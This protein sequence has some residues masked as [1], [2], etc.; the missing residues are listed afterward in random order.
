VLELLERSSQL[1]ELGG[2][3]AAAE[4]GGR[5]VLVAGEAGIGK[6][7]FVKRFSERHSGDVRIL[8]GACDPLLTPRAL[9]P[10]HDIGR[11][12]GGRLAAL[13]TAGVPREQ[14]F[15]A[16]LDE[17]E[18]C[19]SQQVIVVEDAHWADEATLD[20]LVFLGR[21]IERIRALLIVTYRDDELVV[22]HPLRMVIGRLPPE[23]VRHLRLAPLSAAA[24]ADL[25]RRAGRAANGL[26]ALT[27]GNPLLVTEVLAVRDTGVPLT[28]RDL[29]LA[30]LAGLPPD[31]QEV[32]HLVAV[33]PTRTELWL[34]DEALRPASA[35]V[36]A[37]V[38]A[39]LLMA[40]S[41]AVWFR[42]E[43]LR[44]A[45]EGSLSALARRE[46]NQRVLAALAGGHE[47]RVDV[48][49][50]VHHARE[51]GHIDA[52]LQYAPEAAKQAAAVAAHREAVGHYRAV[53]P[54]AGR[55]SA[56]VRAEVLEGYSVEA[57]MSGLTTEAV[58]ARRA[59][60]ALREAAGDREKLGETLRW[61]SRLHWWDGNRPE[62]EA[63]VARAIAVL[64]T[65]PPG[66]QLAMAYS[67]RAGLDML[68][69]RDEAA[70]RGATRTI[71]LAGQ[72]DDREALAHALAIIGSARLNVGDLGGRADLE[73][74]FEVAVA[75]NRVDQAALAL[76]NL[77]TMSSERRD[78]RHARQDLDR[79][80]AFVQA[81][82]LSGWVQHVLGH[83]ARVRLDQGDWAG[84]EQDAR[85]ALAEDVKGGARVVDALVPLG[86]LQARRGQPEAV[87]T[88]QE[89]VERGYATAELQW[90]APVAAARAEH[91]WLLG[92][93]HRIAEEAGPHFGPAVQ[94]AHPWF[95]GEL[96]FW[97]WLAGALPEV[98]PIVAE[99]YRLLLAGDWRAAADAWQE[100]GCPY[101]QA[102][103]L[104]CGDRDET[105]LEA[106]TLLDGLG[107]TQ[108]AQRVRRQ[109]R[110][111]G[112]LRV[113]RGP[114][115]A[116]AANPA[117]LTGRQVEVLGLLAE[118]LTDA[119]IAARLSLSA[120]TVG[121]H[122]SA[123]LAKL[124]V[125]SQREAA[126]VAHRLEV[127]ATKDA[128]T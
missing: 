78:Y 117:R 79:A 112:I 118:G 95:A 30:R 25:A 68:A 119:E 41:D 70:M 12:I 61:L 94:A 18:Q 89:A 22:D 9:G 121:H 127:T 32:V 15:A 43:L 50:L 3:L 83:R 99:P 62:A 35:A 69:G 63:A 104:A 86:L 46:L 73:R 91:A 97:L 53:L 120:K 114:N 6:S 126:A 80:L 1:D 49:R 39:G 11:E 101:T 24:V 125:G 82:E 20:L 123:L 77:A 33:V 81:Q 7:A 27:G 85:A 105:A 51:A 75:A 2:L 71:E 92:E 113:P 87:A 60:V 21:R 110:R 122:V 84:A 64:E 108:T 34:L 23:A 48:A 4:T 38:A 16:F 19:S 58:S 88:L 111:R 54:H 96:A 102:L 90:T 66:H 116:T 93:E 5:V 28:V 36:D 40:S 107:A 37:S 76:G 10:L 47:H 56:L 72:L 59:E 13:L 124:G 55:L 14:L 31:A 67:S 115:R 57:Y 74:G 109:L 45:V 128:A 44:R 17:L 106:L 52:V 8:F 42:H 103:A 26:H 29:V 98:P 65:L 100:L